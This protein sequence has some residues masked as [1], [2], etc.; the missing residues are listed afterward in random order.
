MNRTF[1]IIVHYSDPQITLDCLDSIYKNGRNLST[2]VINNSSEKLPDRINS[3]SH[4]YIINSPKNLGYASANNLG[5][6]M[7][8]KKNARSVI[9]LNND[10]L[11]SN[12]SLPG[13]IS[14]AQ[15]SDKI[16]ILSPKIYF[17][18]GYEFHKTRYRKK[19]LGKVIW[20]AGGQIDWQGVYPKH[21]GVDKVDQGQYDR[22]IQTDFATGCCMLIK[23]KVISKIGFLDENYFLYFEDVDYSL[24]AVSAGF[25]VIYYPHY[26]LWHKNAGSSSGPGSSV[27]QYYQTRN[28]LYFGFKYAGIRTKAAL[29]RESLKDLFSTGLKRKAVLDYYF[30]KMGKGSL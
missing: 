13:F 24:R 5:I 25:Q 1:L 16:G 11:L 2:I 28:R 20:Y 29:F 23:E 7:A 10:T 9:L 17:A 14:Y 8:L 26:Y 12:Q 27:H 3:Y 6:R 22:S 21:R 19:D 4:L 18:K 15:K 30:Q